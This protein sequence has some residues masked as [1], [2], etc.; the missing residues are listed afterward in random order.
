MN[1]GNWIWMRPHY[2]NAGGSRPR[3][4]KQPLSD[5]ISSHRKECA[6]QVLQ[7]AGNAL[8]K[9]SL[10]RRQALIKQHFEL[11]GALFVHIQCAP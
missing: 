10:R 4:R 11:A 7:G 1:V 5:L 2:G 3:R 9:F 6:R 8:W